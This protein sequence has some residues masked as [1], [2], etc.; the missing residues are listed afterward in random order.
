MRWA[1]WI[2]GPVSVAPICCSISWSSRDDSASAMSAKTSEPR[3]RARTS[4]MTMRRM[5]AIYRE[6][7]DKRKTGYWVAAVNSS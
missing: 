4:Q 1:T 6:D 5:R 3:V 2:T 7:G